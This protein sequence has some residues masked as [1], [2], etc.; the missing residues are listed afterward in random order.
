MTQDKRRVLIIDSD[1]ADTEQIKRL[2]EEDKDL[3][4]VYTEESSLHAI[5][6]I[7]SEPPDVIIVSHSLEGGKGR[8][9]CCR[10]RSDTVFG[11]L[12]I[13]LVVGLSGQDLDIDWDNTPVDD[14]LS[15]PRDPWEIRRRISLIFSRAA[16][17]RDANPL[18]RLPGNHSIMREIQGRIDSES[19]F[20]I[21]YVDLDHFKSYNDRYGFLRGDEII[22]MTAR[23][24]TNSIR[25]LDSPRDAGFVLKEEIGILTNSIRNLD[26]PEAFVGHVGGDD[27]VFVVPPNRLD[28]V[29]QEVIKNFDLIVGNF[30]DEDDRIR[31][32]IDSTNRKGEKERFPIMSISIA[33][34]TNEYRPIKHIG[35]V[36]AI[37]AEVKKRLKSMKGSNYVKDMRGSK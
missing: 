21:G 26:S 11:H 2:L 12:P 32:Y 22:K 13:V 34:V 5:E 10:I 16:R 35:E 31:G 3:Y 7:Y 29:C 20:A 25:A 33:I 17:V 28:S 8:E 14:Y 36:G 18:T 19:P 6:T 15:I 4:I 9:L 27:F 23:L 37:A 30:Y 1:G 24:L